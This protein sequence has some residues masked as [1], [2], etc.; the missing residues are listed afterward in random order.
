MQ[1]TQLHY[2]K[3][4]EIYNYI[5]KEKKNPG[6]QIDCESEARFKINT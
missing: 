1:L 6:K 5:Q 2:N 3:R 4:N